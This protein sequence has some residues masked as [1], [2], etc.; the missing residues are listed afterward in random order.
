M[1]NSKRRKK[2]HLPAFPCGPIIIAG[3]VVFPSNPLFFSSSP[4]T[5]HPFQHL[6]QSLCHSR[7]VCQ[8]S[9]QAHTRTHARRYDM[10]S[11]FAYSFQ[12]VKRSALFPVL[13]L[14]S[15]GGVFFFFW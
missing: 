5:S 7:K 13:L 6:C 8:A 4:N 15:L 9:T 1:I 12:C 10:R 2:K 14:V 3:S 11:H